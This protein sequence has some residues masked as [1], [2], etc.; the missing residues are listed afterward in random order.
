[1]SLRYDNF[2]RSRILKN[3]REIFNIRVGEG[4]H[5][6]TLYSIRKETMNKYKTQRKE[7]EDQFQYRRHEV[8]ET[9]AMLIERREQ[10]KLERERERNLQKEK[11]FVAG[12]GHKDITQIQEERKRLREE[13]S[14]ESE[15]KRKEQL[16]AWQRTMREIDATR[17]RANNK[18]ERR[19]NWEMERN[20]PI[21][22]KLA[23]LE[24]KPVVPV[25]VPSSYQSYSSSSYTPSSSTTNYT[26][27]SYSSER[28]APSR[29]KVA[30]VTSTH[31]Y[32]IAI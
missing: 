6:D 30:E 7:R 18:R 25:S 12:K 20:K 11:E 2:Q 31:D 16:A 19:N 24:A 26:S 27:S 32:S 22:I 8:N 28:S 17:E 1:M 4:T 14:W 5:S 9:A 23:N 21:K 10:E 13:A 15:K 3:H 29:G